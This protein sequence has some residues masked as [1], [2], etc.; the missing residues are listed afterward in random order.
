[1]EPTIQIINEKVRQ[2]AVFVQDLLAEIRQVIVGQDRLVQRLLVGLLADQIAELRKER[3][4]NL[5]AP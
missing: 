5:P 1:M 4:E 3:F 2:E